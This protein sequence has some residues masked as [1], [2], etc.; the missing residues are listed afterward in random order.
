M[1]RACSFC[2]WKSRIVHTTGKILNSD[3]GGS[4]KQYLPST[5][6]ETS[7]SRPP[8]SKLNQDIDFIVAKQTF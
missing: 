3:E 6:R 8:V 5:Q 2:P 4:N 1:S 7:Q